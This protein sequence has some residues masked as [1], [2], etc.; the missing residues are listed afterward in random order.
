MS[1]QEV[2]MLKKSLHDLLGKAITL[3]T[4]FRTVRTDSARLIFH[5]LFIKLNNAETFFRSISLRTFI[6]N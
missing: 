1:E 4:Y 5:N 3:K 2:A 6:V